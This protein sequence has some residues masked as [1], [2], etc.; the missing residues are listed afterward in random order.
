MT[1]AGGIERLGFTRAASLPPFRFG[2]RSLRHR[3]GAL[4][5]VL[6]QRFRAGDGAELA[7]RELGDGRPLVLL[8]GFISTAIESWGRPGHAA[9]LAAHGHRVIMPD[10]RGHG[11]S[12]DPH[13]P[14]SY[15]D[16]VLADDGFAL[17]AHLS[18]HD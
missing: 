14:E 1:C 4:P 3:A 2:V 6:V 17:L 5:A 8:H 15:P 9:E 11:D 10:L 12:T 18:L 13:P 16:D 7:F